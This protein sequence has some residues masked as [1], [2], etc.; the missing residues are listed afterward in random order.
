MTPVPSARPRSVPLPRQWGLRAQDVVALVAGN[1]VLIVLMWVRH[2]GL[3]QLGTLSGAFT[4]AGQ[5]AAL[6]GTYLALVGIVLMARSPWLDQAIG[7]DRLAW[8]HR[9]LGFATVWLIGGHVVLTLTGWALGD[10]SDVVS[11]AIGLI[12]GYPYVLWAVV[13]FGL[14]LMVGLTSMGAARRRMSYETWYW[15][16]VYTYLAI[17]L[18]FL[19]QLY[20]G[21]DFTH[22][23]LAVAYWS[24]LYLATAG[25]VVVFRLGQPVVLY[26]RHGFRVGGVVEEAPGVASL[27]VTGRDLDRLPLR[28]GQYFVL[29]F[30]RRDSWW[31][32]HPY[33]I[34][35]APNGA[36]I[37]FTVKALGDDSSSLRRVAP[38]TRVLL[39]G[40]YGVLTG[41]VRTQPKVT[42]IAGG[43]GIAPLRA[44][45][46][47]IA[48]EPGD[49]TLLYRT[50]SARDL[51]F[52][53]E[54]DR[55]AAHRGA[56][57]Q[58]LVGRRGVDL[59]A[60]PLTA[61]TLARL[62]PDI[63]DQD[64]YLCGPTGLMRRT[65]A[66]LRELGVPRGQIHAERFSY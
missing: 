30:L 54:L 65:E 52:R 61:T 10:G 24:S 53:D 17:A 49:L 15:L 63:A 26:A 20:V 28:S 11:E 45:L 51:V 60:D 29:R 44:L 27:Y 37:R 46:E 6:L 39:E 42:L 32:A 18:A 22:D 36:W 47:S 64:V 55:L 23:P 31:R 4:A 8:A 35:S 1:V 66:A 48:G 2:G 21:A 25:L 56:T 38:G 58:Y 13:G 12:A 3:D 62:V 14:F 43:I 7:P 9:W 34:S 50:A 40:P 16:H 59:P 5:L 41:A 57:V 19:H 33:S